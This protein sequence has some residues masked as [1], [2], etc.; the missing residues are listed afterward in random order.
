[1]SLPVFRN[2]ILDAETPVL[3]RA[4]SHLLIAITRG[5]Y[6]DKMLYHAAVAERLLEELARAYPEMEDHQ[7]QWDFAKAVLNEIQEF[8]RAP[9]G[10]PQETCYVS[11]WLDSVEKA[12]LGPDTITGV[13][14]PEVPRIQ[15]AIFRNEIPVTRRCDR[16]LRPI[17]DG[18]PERSEIEDDVA[19]ESDEEG[20]ELQDDSLSTDELEGETLVGSDSSRDY[21]FVGLREDST[22]EWYLSYFR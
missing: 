7:R 22:E 21:A 16:V 14:Y 12:L 4:W 9:E 3:F 13:Q 2:F 18:R 8:A 17:M 5:D 19:V 1:M 20:S 10:R 15:C 11:T 6:A